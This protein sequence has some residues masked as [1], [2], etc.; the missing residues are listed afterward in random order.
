MIG[1]ADA[2]TLATSQANAEAG[3]GDSV[4]GAGTVA[5]PGRMI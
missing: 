5:G 3:G 4:V 2:G 1:E